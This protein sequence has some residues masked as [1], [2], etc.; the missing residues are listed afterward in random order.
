MGREAGVDAAV[1]SGGLAAPYSASVFLGTISTREWYTQI[2]THL[3]HLN[4]DSIHRHH[5]CYQRIRDC[6]LVIQYALRRCRRRLLT[7]IQHTRGN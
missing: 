6:R 4:I 5:Q 1:A 7:I 2:Y 3:K